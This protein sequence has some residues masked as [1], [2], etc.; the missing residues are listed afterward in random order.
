MLSEIVIQFLTTFILSGGVAGLVVW[1]T[2]TWLSE[3]IRQ[4]IKGEFDQ[5]LETHKAQLKAQSD[6]EIEKLKSNLKS[7]SDIELEKLRSQLNLSNK[8]HE[9]RFAHLHGKRAET[10]AEIYASL[11]TLYKSLTEY[12]QPFQ[13]AGAPSRDDLRNRAYAD[14]KKF[15][16]L[17][18]TKL[19]FLPRTTADKI[20]EIN[21]ELVITFNRFLFQVEMPPPGQAD[22]VAWTDIF[23]KIKSEINDA[24]EELADEFRKLMG[25]NG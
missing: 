10:I 9:L 17:Y 12:T 6:I 13:A 14:H 7:Q 21:R 3:R 15:F 20:E 8:E 5:K 11:K 18:F 4:S 1:L 19:I 24:L 2:R 16:D 25:D 23:E 22:A